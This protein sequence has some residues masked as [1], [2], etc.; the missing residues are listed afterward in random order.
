MHLTFLRR[1]GTV[2]P[3]LLL[4]ATIVFAQPLEEKVREH[5]FANGLKLLVVERHESPT[6]AAYIT[7]GVGSVHETSQQ[8]GVAHL[9]EHMLFKGTKTLGTTDYAR[10]KPLL[11]EIE[12]VGSVLDA[13]KNRPEVD[14]QKVAE[15]RE[16]LAKLQQ[17]H[18]QFVV[19]D[20]FSR[21]YAENGGVGYNA[22]T[23]KDLTTYLISLPAN[24]IELWAA[25]EADRMQN[26]VLREFYTEREVVREERRRSYESSPDGLLYENLIATAFTVHPYRHPVIGWDSDIRNLSLAETRDFL[27][28][29]YA[30]A[31]TVIALVGDID[32]EVAIAMVERYF[33]PIPPGIPVP[34]VTA[35]EPTPRG[36]KRLHIEFEAEPQLAIAF[37]KPTLPTRDDY[38]FDLIDLI[39]A[40]GRTSR[41]YRALVVEKEL[42]TAVGTYGAP[43]SRYDNLFVISATPRHPHTT[44]EVETAIYA[45][46]ERLGREPVSAEELEQARNRLRV[47]RLRRLQGNN[48]LARMLTYYQTVA[49]DWRYLVTY[50]REV[51]TISAEEVMAVARTYFTSGRRVVVTLGKGGA[52]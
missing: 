4:G 1:L 25:I 31:N 24:K 16:R 5:T 15:L 3:L 22:F 7:I 20:E 33:G 44:A 28:R 12:K 30:P 36:E 39:L 38:I 19:K 10:E 29:Y 41:L 50:D 14:P 23:S 45:E 9:L 42:A 13:L 46:L 34:P 51:A 8:R 52:Q 2:L 40:N 18:K 17:E 6:V 21:I 11:E 26:A 37:H 43:G 48:G 47:D 49:G 32:T 27:H 35:A